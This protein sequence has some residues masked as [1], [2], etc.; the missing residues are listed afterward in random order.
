M[1][2]DLVRRM[3]QMLNRCTV[4]ASEDE[5][6][7]PICEDRGYIFKKDEYGN[8]YAE[9]C[10]C[11][12]KKESLRK[13]ERSG[14]SEAFKK[15][16]F[17]NYI[18]EEIHQAQAKTKALKY[19]NTFQET[20]ASLILCGQPG[21]GKTHLGIASML[22]LINNNIGAR[23]EEYISM[24][25]NLKQASMD[26]VNY[27]KTLEK[28]I[29]PKVLFLDDFLK[30]IPNQADL[31]YI[32]EVIN[33]RYLKGKPMIISTEKS[34]DEILDWDEAVGSRLIEMSQGNIIEFK[35]NINN[36]YRLRGIV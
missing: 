17:D 9:P 5:Y 21:A 28:Y 35:N 13:L 31:K 36:N 30:G 4:E 16:T 6:D 12:S 3:N 15:K 34:M 8:E 26:Q 33:T 18:V 11:L 10:K 14:L 22:K 24:L 7:C 27:I 32:Y 1:D 25:L 2:A 20:N 23:Y 19:C 29:N